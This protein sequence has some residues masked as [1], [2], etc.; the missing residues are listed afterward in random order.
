MGDACVKIGT[1]KSRLATW[2]AECIGQMLAQRWPDLQYSLELF[3]TTGDRI[4]DQPLPEIGG[5][6]LFTQELEDALQRGD[7]HLVV[8]S[9][10]DLPVEESPGL[11]MAAI[12]PRESAGDV[13]VSGRGYTLETL[14]KG[15]RVGT[16]SL[17]RSAQLLHRRPDLEIR[18][19]RGN[20]DT[21]IRK[22]YQGEYDAIVLAAAGVNRL[23]LQAQVTEELSLQ[24]MLPAPGQGALAVQCRSDNAA[25]LSLLQAIDHAETRAAVLAERAFLQGLGGGCSAPVAAYGFVEAGLL[26]LEGLV[27]S[28]DGREVIRIRHSM[29]MAAGEPGQPGIWLAKQALDLGAA[30]FL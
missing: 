9:L 17:R 14:P 11:A 4:P 8:H 21:R 22:A 5:K 18:P 30:R 20:I 6:G 15:A 26:H 1:R 2:Q 7:I 10:K 29:A 13:L 12:P 3:D 23:G 27:A 19:L 24:V 25:L 28:R 16:S